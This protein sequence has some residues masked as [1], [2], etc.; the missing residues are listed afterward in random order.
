MLDRVR[1]HV[2]SGPSVIQLDSDDITTPIKAS[3]WDHLSNEALVH[4][5]SHSFEQ[6]QGKEERGE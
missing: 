2:F 4:L 5:V 6:G 1:E 3:H